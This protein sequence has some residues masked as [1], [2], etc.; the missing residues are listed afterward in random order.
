[1]INEVISGFYK[2]AESGQ[3]KE[4]LQLRVGPMLGGSACAALSYACKRHDLNK[5]N[6]NAL[7]VLTR[8]QFRNM[9]ILKAE[10]EKIPSVKA[11]NKNKAIKLM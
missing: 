3:P 4:N 9:K 7:W 11:T 1:M 2:R 6:I 10:I 5:G 8:Q